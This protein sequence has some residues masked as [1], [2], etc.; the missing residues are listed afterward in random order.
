MEKLPVL[1]SDKIIKLLIKEGFSIHRQ[2][3]SHIVLYKKENGKMKLAVVPQTKELSKG[4]FLSII[5][6][7]G[8]T[9]QEFLVLLEKKGR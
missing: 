8:Y 6:Q 1:S 7:S 3:G 4:T 2:K 9:K 5:K